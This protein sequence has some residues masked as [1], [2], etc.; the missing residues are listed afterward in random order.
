LKFTSPSSIVYEY[1]L[2]GHDKDW[3]ILT[4]GSNELYYNNLP[5]GSYKLRVRSEGN[6]LSEA[7]MEFKINSFFTLTFGYR[8]LCTL[9]IYFSTNK[10]YYA[11]RLIKGK[12]TTV[13]NSVAEKKAKPMRNI[14]FQKSQSRD[15]NL[16]A[17]N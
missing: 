1:K 7:Q 17:K 12:V 15:V 2:E 9:I 5:S 14:K 11:F 10:L 6:P 3:Q 13:T 16:F 8:I 4:S